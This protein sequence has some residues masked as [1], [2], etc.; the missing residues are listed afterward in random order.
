VT[1]RPA[2]RPAYALPSPLTSAVSARRKQVEPGERSLTSYLLLPRPGDLAKAVIV[3]VSFALGSAAVGGTTAS[4]LFHGLVVWLVLELLVYQ[5]RY[6]WNDIRGFAADHRHPDRSQRGRLPGP[7]DHAARHI[8]I[9]ALVAAARLAGAAVI[10]LLVRDI[11]GVVAAMTVAVF[12]VAALYETLRSRATGRTCQMPVPVSAA[13]RGLWLVVGA[14]YA[15]RGMT[16]LSLAVN[17]HHRLGA[18]AA[19]TIAMWALGVVFVTCRWALEALCLARFDGDRVVWEVAP[20]TAREHS[21]ALTRWLPTGP[22]DVVDAVHPTSP[23]QWRALSARTPG[24]A[25]WNIA[26]VVA[27]AAATVAGVLLAGFP[28][29]LGFLLACLLGLAGGAGVARVEHRRF[30]VIA[31]MAVGLAILHAFGLSRACV[32]GGVACLLVL[33]AYAGFTRQC[34]DDIGQGIVRLTRLLRG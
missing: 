25:P 30:L 19:A 34:A 4:R 14:G 18:A 29:G 8:T 32:S 20:G 16:G 22:T 24:T 7:S 6:Q 17:L 10:A 31:G 15:V 11:A 27:A 1:I 5:A 33:E 26:V 12:A 28:T 23:K 13:L 2:E 3:P 21:L 9:S